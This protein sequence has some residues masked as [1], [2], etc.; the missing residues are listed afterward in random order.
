M[1]LQAYGLGDILFT[2]SIA[3]KWHQDGYQILWGINPIYLGIAKHFPWI[4]FVDYDLLN[5]D[6][7]SQETTT[8]GN[9][10][11]VPLRWAREI[12]QAPLQ[13]VQRAKYDLVNIPWENWKD[14]FLCFRD[15]QAEYNLFYKVLDLDLG[16]KYNLV[17]EHYQTGG[18]QRSPLVIDNGLRNV[19]LTFYQGYTLIDWLTVIE[20]AT[21]IH[22]VSSSSIYLFE[23]Y[24]TQAQEVHLY[25]RKPEE[26]DHEHYQYLLNKKYIFTNKKTKNGSI[27]IY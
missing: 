10:T 18:K 19:Y 3:R 6:Y 27:Q 14:G 11:I 4:T 24:E 8:R 16:E 25:P 2:I 13:D 17:S 22:A 15:L 20:N 1:P 12:L 23:L 5:I 7:S 26:M 21:T 9:A